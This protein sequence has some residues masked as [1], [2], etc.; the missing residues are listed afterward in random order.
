MLSILIV[1]VT[2][3]VDFVKK[4]SGRGNATSFTSQ[5]KGFLIKQKTMLED[6]EIKEK[7]EDLYD[8]TSTDNIGEEEEDETINSN[9]SKED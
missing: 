8:D 5:V 6:F 4:I 1:C 3:S 7:T 9:N 2:T